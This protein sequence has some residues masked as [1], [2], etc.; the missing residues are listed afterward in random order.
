MRHYS[1]RLLNVFAE[2]VFGG[3]PLCVFEDGSGLDTA[4]MQALARQFNL[5]ETT[6][7]LPPSDEQDVAG[8]RIFT[9]EQEM[10]FAGHPTLGSAHVVRDVLECGDHFSLRLPA[11]SYAVRADAN[12]WQLSAPPARSRPVSLSREALA[13]LVGLSA[14]AVL[15]QALWVSCGVEMLLLP[16]ADMEALAAA[17]PDVAHLSRDAVSEDGLAAVF[18][19]A[20]VCQGAISARMFFVANGQALEDP[21]TGSAVAALGGWWQAQGHALPAALVVNQGVHCGRTSRLYLD[22]DDHGIRVAG[23]VWEL[24]RGSVTLPV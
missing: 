10:P 14:N 1:Y 20:P 3:N 17:T 24:G 5:S 11:G 7:I 19:W 13:A 15:D 9:P 16:L 23:Q 12:Y 8:L 4:T 18:L 22:I 21:A 6:F 2:T